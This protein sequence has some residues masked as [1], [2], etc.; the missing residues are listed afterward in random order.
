MNIGYNIWLFSLIVCHVLGCDLSADAG[1]SLWRCGC[2]WAGEI[3]SS[4]AG[5]W[6]LLMILSCLMCV[7]ELHSPVFVSRV[8]R[9]QLKCVW[10]SRPTGLWKHVCC[11]RL[12]S[13]SRGLSI[14]RRWRRRRVWALTAGPSS[15]AYLLKYRSGHGY[16]G[17]YVLWIISNY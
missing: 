4:A 6:S 10:S 9:L 12:L 8:Q 3:R 15:P 14:W 17:G 11:S 1:F 5:V 16:R 7:D 2:V 13:R